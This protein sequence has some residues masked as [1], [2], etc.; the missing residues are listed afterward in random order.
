MPPTWSGG[1]ALE[2]CFGAL[3]VMGYCFA[4]MTRSN[5]FSSID[6]P[7]VVLPSTIVLRSWLASRAKD[8]RRWEDKVSRVNRR[9]YNPNKATSY[10]MYDLK[11]LFFFVMGVGIPD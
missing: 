2:V 9:K 4:S 7:C 1:L 5:V 10:Y 3:L 6:T 11:N 8:A